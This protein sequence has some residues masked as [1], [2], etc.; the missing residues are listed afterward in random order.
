MG[1]AA[2]AVMVR[3]EKDIVQAAQVLEV[4][5][6]ARPGDLLPAWDSLTSVGRGWDRAA[7]RGL[8]LLGRRQPAVH[9]RI[10]RLLRSS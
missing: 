3:R 6:E 1:A 2:V 10:A 4:L 8:A 7:R 5:I 9:A